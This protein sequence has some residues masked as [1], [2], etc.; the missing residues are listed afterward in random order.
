VRILLSTDG[1]FSFPIVL[2]NNTPN[3]GSEMVTIP[4]T[5]TGSARVKVE[6][7]GNVFFNIS[8]SNFTIF[9]PANNTPTITSFSPVNGMVGTSVTITGTNFINP[10]TVNFN[11]ISGTSFTLNSTTEIVTTVPAGAT[12]GAITVTTPSG[13]ATS[14]STFTVGQSPATVQ[15]NSTNYAVAENGGSATITV[16]RTGDLSGV[17]RVEY[18]T[19]DLTA[20]QRTDYMV[21]AGTLTF[22][23]G[24]TSRTFSVPIV[25]DAYV[26]GSEQL[27][28]I[29]SN[30]TGASLGTSSAIL[31]INDNDVFPPTTNPSDTAGFFVRQ[32]YLDFLSRE[33]DP[34]GL[35]F[36]T[37]Q[38][39]DA[40]QPTDTICLNHRR[41]DVSDAFFFESEFQ[42]T[43]GFIFRVYRA[44]FGNT[45]PFP[46]S[47]P[48]QPS[49]AI[50]LPSYAAFIGDRPTIISGSGVAQSQQEFAN[51]FVQR[52]AFISRYPLSLDG[53]GFVDAIL[54]SIQVSSGVD[55]LSQRTALINLY[56]NGGRG[57][58]LYRLAD[59]NTQTNP[60]DN[61]LLIDAEYRR[62]FVFTEYAGYLRRDADIG[63]FLFWLNEVNKFP[64]RDVG[65]QH[66]MACAFISSAEYQKRF[67][68]VVNHSNQECGQ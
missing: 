43:G 5:P 31:M 64:V 7:V 2:A 41:R 49:E 4:T 61:H 55:L 23:A 32:H 11:G 52:A 36:W 16:S 46:N 53:P 59:D 24:D 20:L 63:G 12:N 33:P 62:T 38:I 48:A 51:A 65:I 50:K 26:E 28:L 27:S 14:L 58:V 35:G 68:S 1:G 9:G 34:G 15:F 18:A 13:T 67:S 22:A 8:S 54:N 19:A 66:T 30:P 21:S 39:T 56:N 17:S 10:Q 29:L 57:A 3:D 6:A 47:D 44:A 25:D 60:I 45:Q 42:Q 37:G 40:C